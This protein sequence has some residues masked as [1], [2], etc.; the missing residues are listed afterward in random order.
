MKKIIITTLVA[1]LF[2]SNIFAA[3]NDL[4]VKVEPTFFD[5]ANIES[6]KL[7]KATV[8]GDPKADRIFKKYHSDFLMR[9]KK[10]NSEMNK[11]LSDV[12]RS[13][14]QE[15]KTGTAYAKQD[16][17]K[18][19]ENCT[20]VKTEEQHNSCQDFKE[21][22]LNITEQVKGLKIQKS[23]LIGE[24]N[25]DRKNR[26]KKNYIDYKNMVGT[27]KAQVESQK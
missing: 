26:I 3:T 21:Q 18:Y 2:S 5:E 13:I 7:V 8:S 20:D 11:Y 4:G 9:L 25:V 22:I 10:I 19:D 17:K 6:Y 16:Q 27:L 12:S 24:I 15:I 14:D 23:N 1:T